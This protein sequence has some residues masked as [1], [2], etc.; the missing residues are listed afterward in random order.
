M[1]PNKP[2]QAAKFHTHLQEENPNQICIVLENNVDSERP[3]A[4]VKALY[5]GLSSPPIFTDSLD[6]LQV[7]EVDITDLLEPRVT[8][9]A[10]YSQATGMV[11]KV[12]EQIIRGLTKGIKGADLNDWLTTQEENGK[13]L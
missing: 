10:D 9:K 7:F 13:N 12:D 2:G 4:Y 5:S 11:N 8:N 3:R 1:R 6:D